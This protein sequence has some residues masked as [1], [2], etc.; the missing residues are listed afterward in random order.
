[1]DAGGGR[2]PTFATENADVPAA[3]WPMSANPPLAEAFDRMDIVTSHAICVDADLAVKAD[4]R[5]TD[6]GEAGVYYLVSG[7]M[8]F[9][10]DKVM[11][12]TTIYVIA[13]DLRK[14]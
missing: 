6:D 3:I 8:K 5:I 2:T 10:N 13:A 11:K 4:D 14:V 7:A 9:A 12:N 1:M